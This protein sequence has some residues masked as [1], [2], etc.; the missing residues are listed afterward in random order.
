MKRVDVVYSLIY[1]EKTDKVLMVHNTKYDNWSMPGGVVE[2]GETLMEAA[3]REAREE[4]GLTIEVQNLVSVNEVFMKENGHH[5]VFIT[6]KA[7]ILSGE[8]SIQDT[9][10]ISDVQW[11]DIRTANEWMPYHSKGIDLFLENSVP[12]V[13][14]GTV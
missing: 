12:Y 13:F 11:M 5:A 4:T 1:D 10:T 7:R 6:F 9:D 14:Q 2:E 3:I 8:I